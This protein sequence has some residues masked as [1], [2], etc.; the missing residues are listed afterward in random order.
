MG[1][2]HERMVNLD[3]CFSLVQQNC[4]KGGISAIEIAKKLSK[5]RTTI[6]RYLTSL[7][8]MGKIESRGGR[9]YAKTGEQTI[10][11]LEKEIVIELPLPR[12]KWA[13]VARLQVHVDYLESM[14]LPEVASM[15]K[16]LIDKFNETR[17][18]RI[19][20]KNVDD[21]DLEKLGNLIQQANQKSSLFNFKSLF[22]GL[23]KSLHSN[24]TINN[25]NTKETS[26]SWET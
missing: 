15:E 5:D 17:T 1:K 26:R 18:I 23:R 11:P 10:K 21:L 2:E 8:L 19:R 4:T 9:W 13:D 22:K 3:K 20:G 12:N 16:T 14:G 25:E 6:H 7:D 24:G